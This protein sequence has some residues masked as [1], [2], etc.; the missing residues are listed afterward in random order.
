MIV[1][2]LMTVV[3][4]PSGYSFIY[5]PNI[6]IG[7]LEHRW[8]QEI[9]IMTKSWIYATLFKF[10]PQCGTDLRD[11]VWKVWKSEYFPNHNWRMDYEYALTWDWF[12]YVERR[13]S[14]TEDSVGSIL[15]TAFLR[16]STPF[17]SPFS[18]MS[19]I[20]SIDLDFSRP[21]SKQKKLWTTHI[22]FFRIAV[23]LWF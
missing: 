20:S 12:S 13:K 3:R 14:L 17:P 18:V 4:K 11:N 7:C 22:D 9:W 8:C 15:A 10:P 5:V 1:T 21:N 2:S 16:R 23:C 19:G 6:I